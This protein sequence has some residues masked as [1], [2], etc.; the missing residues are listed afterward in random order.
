[1]LK[2]DLITNPINYSNGFAKVPEGPGWGVKLDVTAL[3]RFA[4]AETTIID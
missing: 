4:S 2:D 1:M 3:N